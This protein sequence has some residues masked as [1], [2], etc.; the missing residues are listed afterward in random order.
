M[1]KKSQTPNFLWFWKLS[2]SAI[3]LIP[4]SMKNG[5][6]PDPKAVIPD[7]KTVIPDPTLLQTFDPWSHIPCYYPAIKP[8]LK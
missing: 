2:H 8:P 5:A 4:D 1:Q 7:P 3:S 6:D